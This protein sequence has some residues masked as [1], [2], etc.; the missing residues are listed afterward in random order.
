MSRR[1]LYGVLNWGLGHATRSS[2]IIRELQNQGFEPILASDGAAGEWLQEE[3]PHLTYRELPS[4]GIRYSRSNQQW[5]YLFSRLPQMAAAASRERKL[6]EMWAEDFD[7]VGI[8]SDNRLGFCSS[9]IPSAYLSH[10]LSP[11]AGLFTSIA[12]L[13]HRRYYQHFTELWIP[14]REGSPLSGGLSKGNKYARNI[15]MLSALSHRESDEPKSAL[16][17]LS[18]P[19]PQRSILEQMLF[20][21]AEALPENSVLVRGINGACPDR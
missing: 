20:D 19:E 16:M 1:V 3:F 13:A 14:D 2:V 12:G 7:A 17:I 10:Q 18:G 21:Q 9:T 6:A 11:K 4:Y 8:V 5:P 15:G